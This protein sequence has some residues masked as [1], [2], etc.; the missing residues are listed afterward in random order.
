MKN[1]LEGFDMTSSDEGRKRRRRQLLLPGVA[2]TAFLVVGMGGMA[3]AA[4]VDQQVNNDKAAGIDPHRPVRLKDP[5]NADVVGGALVAGAPAVPWATFQQRTAHADQVFARAFKDGAWTTQGDGTTFGLSSGAPA[6]RGSLNFDQTKNGEAPSIDFA[7]AGRATPWATW[8]EDGTSGFQSHK[9]VFIS[10]F[11]SASGKWVFTGGA[12]GAA[13]GT[14]VPSLNIHVD[15]NAINP[16]VAGGSTLDPTRPAPWVTWQETGASGPGA[17]RQQIFVDKPIPGATSCNANQPQQGDP[18]GGFCF[19]DTGAQR[20][21]ADPSLNV[22]RTRDGVEPDIAFTGAND[23]VPWVVWYEQ[24]HSK[25]GLH[26]NEMVFASKAVPS[27]AAGVNGGFQWTVVGSR[28]QGALDGS[29][30]GGTCGMSPTAEG[31]CSLNANAGAS[32]E[33]PRI[34]AGTMTPGSPTVP[35]ITW[36][37]GGQVFVSRLVGTGADARFVIA[38]HGRPIASGTRADIT[39]T[40]NTPVVTWHRGGQLR[41]GHFVTPDSFAVDGG[42]VGTQVSA[43]VRA[44][45]SS[46]CIATPFNADGAMCQGGADGAPFFLLTEG[47]AADAKLVGPVAPGSRVVSGPA[48]DDAERPKVGLGVVRTHLSVL[49]RTASLRVRVSVNEAARVT[50]SLDAL[51]ARGRAVRSE[52]AARTTVRFAR[53]GEKTVTLKLSRQAV[54]VLAHEPR[55]R[56][57]VG[58]RATAGDRGR[59]AGGGSASATRAITFTLKG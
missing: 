51:G 30:D 7:G 6:F 57:T 40:R 11:D 9:Q 39:F 32:G 12:R 23:S 28:A 31:D 43:A 38:N 17:G 19:Q 10:R 14:P 18:V 49:R 55:A 1:E 22:D 21:G 5:T 15:K 47:D 52:L 24:N 54:G 53:A 56:L 41:S 35:W 4:A 26:N 33:D 16:S 25:A 50:V 48:D 37:E 58:A 34:A 42:P 20:L 8:Y 46:S 45:I 44:P 3:R 59:A 27:T 13:R 29:A 2:L 36:D